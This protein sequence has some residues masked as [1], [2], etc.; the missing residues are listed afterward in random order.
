MRWTMFVCKNRSLDLYSVPW[1]ALPSNTG[2]MGADISGCCVTTKRL[3]QLRFLAS[4]RSSRSAAVIDDVVSRQT[5][6]LLCCVLN[7]GFGVGRS[8]ESRSPGSAQERQED[9]P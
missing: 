3:Q 9:D 7:A 5:K 6:A 1:L 4:S 2:V 8:I